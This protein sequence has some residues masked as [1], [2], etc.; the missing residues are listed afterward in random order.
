MNFLAV[1]LI[2]HIHEDAEPK[3][4]KS[5][6]LQANMWFRHCHTSLFC[7]FFRRCLSTASCN[8]CFHSRRFSPTARQTLLVPSENWRWDCSGPCRAV[9]QLHPG[10]LTWNLKMM[11]WK[12]IFLFNWVVFRFHVNLPGW[13]WFHVF[14]KKSPLFGEMIQFDEKIF[15]LGWN[16]QLVEQDFLLA[17]LDVHRSDRN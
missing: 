17:Y 14:F 5:E 2:V 8:I 15:P 9:G 4:Y 16:H 7:F 10:R 12:M 13:W 1:Q 6:I 3:L 11:V